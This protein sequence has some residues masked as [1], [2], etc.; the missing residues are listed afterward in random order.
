MKWEPSARDIERGT[1]CPK[2]RA[3]SPLF[4]C[5]EVDIGVGVQEFNH[6]YVCPEHGQ[7]GFALVDGRSEPVFLDDAPTGE[8]IGKIDE[9]EFLYRGGLL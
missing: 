4:D 7:F 3:L 1:E 8:E 9:N 5:Q 6:E 2:C